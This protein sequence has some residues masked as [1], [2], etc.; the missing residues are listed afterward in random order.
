MSSAPLPSLPSLQAGQAS[1]VGLLSSC[2]YSC[3]LILLW[4]MTQPRSGDELFLLNRP[5][6]DKKS[7]VSWRQK[8]R[9][10]QVFQPWLVV[11]SK[12][13]KPFIRAIT[14][15]TRP[16]VFGKM[17]SSVFRC[18]F[19]QNY[20]LHPRKPIVFP[21]PYEMLSMNEHFNGAFQP[22]VAEEMLVLKIYQQIG[23]IQNAAG[24]RCWAGCTRAHY[25]DYYSID[26]MQKPAWNWTMENERK[27]KNE[28]NKVPV[29]PKLL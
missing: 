2:L 9:K 1:L 18:I 19:L 25:Y 10:M 7:L 5:L 8:F 16:F 4:K 13:E 26:V 23:Y 28:G 3:I 27:A 22:H 12:Q 14:I 6:P 24:T 11:T 29:C 21:L 15:H 17:F 20:Y